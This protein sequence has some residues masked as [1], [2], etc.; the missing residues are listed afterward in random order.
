ALT[1]SGA[2]EYLSDLAYRHGGLFTAHHVTQMTEPVPVAPAGT[3]AEFK[4]VITSAEIRNLTAVSLHTREHVFGVILF[5][6]ADRKAFGASGPRLMVGLALQLGLTIDNYV[7]AHDAH[8]RTQEYEL[9]TE[10]GQAISSRLD[11]DE[12]LRTI[13]AELGQIFNNSNFYIA[14]QNGDEICFELEVEDDL[15]LPKRRR[16]LENAFTEYVIRSGQPLL[17]RSDLEKTRSRLGITYRP[18]QPA[19]CLCAAPILLGGKAAGVM[20]AMS[21]A[22]EYVFEQRDVDV[23]MTAAGQVS[24]AVENARLFA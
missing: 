2:G 16:K 9:L 4:K 23:L 8:R 3:F 22:R 10:I 18:E 12:V 17:I 7:V 20:V 21:T 24:V 6:H 15:V 19:K 13:H 11:Q 1:K 14:F 5:P